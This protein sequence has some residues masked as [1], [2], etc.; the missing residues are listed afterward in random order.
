MDLFTLARPLLRCLTPEAAHRAT[1]AGLRAGLAGRAWGADTPVLAGTVFGLNFANPVGLAPGFDKNAVAAQA[2]AALGFGFV[3]IGG[4][5]PRPHPGNPRPRVFRLVEDEAV[6]N[7]LGFNNKGLDAVARRIAVVGPLPCPLGANLGIN[8]GAADPAAD[9]VAGVER[10]GPRVDYVTVNISS[11][12]TPGLR[13][14][15]ERAA[16]DALLG[17]VMEAR[18]RLP[19]RPRALPVLVKIAPDL[20]EAALAGV[21]ETVLAR[22][23][24]GLVIG[25]TMTARPATLR[26]R[27][28]AETGGLS[29]RPLFEPSTRMLANVYRMT[30]GALPL[31]GVGGIA[32]GEDAY[33][34]ICAGASLV[35]LYTALIYRGPGLIGRIKADLARQLAADGFARISDAVGRDAA[36]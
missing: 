23:V 20:D 4:V 17:R 35:Q 21:V 29:G 14:L 1:L 11:P 8:K 2:L 34:K 31:I 32:S 18:N 7:R 26:S 27:H 36:D 5:T 13:D 10:L 30:G 33:A 24:N 6:I 15:Q 25:N 22:N 19:V 9:F 16:L 28:R 3:E 12:N